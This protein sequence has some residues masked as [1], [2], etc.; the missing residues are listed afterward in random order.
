MNTL[1]KLTMLLMSSL[2]MTSFNSC[3]KE[4]DSTTT[5]SGTFLFSNTNPVPVGNYTLKLSEAASPGVPAINPVNPSIVLGTETN[6]NG[7]FVFAF[8]STGAQAFWGPTNNLVTL[9]NTETPSLPPMAIFGFPYNKSIDLSSL[10]LCKKVDQVIIRVKFLT[11]IGPADS[12]TVH[13]SDLTGTISHVKAGLTIPAGSEVNVDTIVN[14]TFGYKDFNTKK[15][16]PNFTIVPMSG[17]HSFIGNV[18]DSLSQFDEQSVTLKFT[19][20]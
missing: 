16:I 1:P 10:Y 20:N 2:L 8:R 13:A 7:N 14:G 11:A 5:I 19:C 18:T 4:N 9:S 12:F 15:Y 17:L 3:K 6:N